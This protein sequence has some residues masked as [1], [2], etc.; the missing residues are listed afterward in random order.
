MGFARIHLRILE[1]GFTT[2]CLPAV[3]RAPASAIGFG[4]GH[5]RGHGSVCTVSFPSREPRGRGGT[6]SFHARSSGGMQSGSA[7]RSRPTREL[8]PINSS[9]GGLGNLRPH[10]VYCIP[11]L[12]EFL[13]AMDQCATRACFVLAGMRQPNAFLVPFWERVHGT[14]RLPM[15]S[16]REAIAVAEQVG[17]AP[18]AIE[19]PATKRHRFRDEAEARGYVY[20]RLRL[21]PTEERDRAIREVLDRELEAQEGG[22][23]ARTPHPD[24]VIWW[25]AG[26]RSTR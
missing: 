1:P 2:R 25:E 9:F 6:F 20:A 15:P 22:F 10:V 12:A 3:A 13:L 14:A 5:R 16:G 26:K 17:L 21:T 24:V 7:Q 18:H 4:A 11:A 8:A 19:L 23:Q